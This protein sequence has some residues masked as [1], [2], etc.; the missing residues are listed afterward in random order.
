[1]K[2][3]TKFL[4]LLLVCA[5]LSPQAVLARQKAS[6]V[7]ELR[8]RITKLESIDQD[9]ATAPE[10]RELNSTF[11][12]E[13]RAH[14]RAELKKRVGA[15]EAYLSS[16]A[17]I[18]VEAEAKAVRASIQNLR[19]ELQSL[20]GGEI[21]NDSP[22]ESNSPRFTPVSYTPAET[23]S[24]PILPQPR[25]SPPRPHP[26]RHP[27]TRCRSRGPHPD[28]RVRQDALGRGRGHLLR[29]EHRSED[30]RGL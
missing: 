29:S 14:L 23:V 13:R 27:R 30:R 5:L 26:R 28:P 21:A 7:K 10:V 15:L 11:L 4:A 12:A 6:T 22:I 16:G 20:D 8:E 9:P 17:G 1:M 3:T 25:Q 24:H 2:A 19:A 18:L